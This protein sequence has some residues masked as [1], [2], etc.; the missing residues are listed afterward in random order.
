MALQMALFDPKY[1]TTRSRNV[2]QWLAQWWTLGVVLIK[3]SLIST[4]PC[5]T[6]V[7]LKLI[8]SHI[9]VSISLIVLVLHINLDL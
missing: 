6:V 9:V 1:V 7:E 2:L 3:D 8:Q 5:A 4:L